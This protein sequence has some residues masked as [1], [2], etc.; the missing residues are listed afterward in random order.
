MPKYLVDIAQDF[1]AHGIVEIE[2]KDD[3]D[4]AALVREEVRLWGD[5]RVC[6]FSDVTLDPDWGSNWNSRALG[7]RR[8]ADGESVD[9]DLKKPEHFLV[10]DGNAYWWEGD[11]NSGFLMTAPV[12]IAGEPDWNMAGD[13][14]E[15]NWSTDDHGFTWSG[16]RM[17][18]QQIAA[19]AEAKRFKEAA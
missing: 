18:T 10:L 4:A 13:V 15:G 14:C 3:F 8:L 12:T 11:Y 2:A 1:T 16:I 5:G 6:L 7:I 17:V 9:P 19:A